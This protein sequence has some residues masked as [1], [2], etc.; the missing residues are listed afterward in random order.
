VASSLKRDV[1]RRTQHVL[2]VRGHITR[3]HAA[4]GTAPSGRVDRPGHQQGR[5]G[6]SNACVRADVVRILAPRL[7]HSGTESAKT[8]GARCAAR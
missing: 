8:G 2:A 4:F 7:S 1:R 6:P 3:P 5:A